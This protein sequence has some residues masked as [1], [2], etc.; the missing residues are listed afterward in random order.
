MEI[1]KIDK[2][3]ITKKT[4]IFFQSQ[5][6]KN[7]LVF[8]VFVTI[9]F[10]FWVMQYF[11]QTMEREIVLSVDY[12]NC[13]KDIVVADSVP[14]ELT[15]KIVD[16][17]TAF[18]KYH[19]SK[20]VLEIDMKD[21]PVDTRN[22][23]TIDR[24]ALNYK[25]IDFLDN[26]SQ[27]TSFKPEVLDVEYATLEKKELPIRINGNLL[28]SPGYIFTD[29]LHIEPSSVWVYG[30]KESI[31]TL[32]YISTVEVNEDNIQKDLDLTIDLE[33]PRNVSL[34]AQKVKVYTGI[35]E[36]T[37]KII[38]LPIVCYNIPENITVRFFPSTA[39]VNCRI[40]LSKYSELNE[41]DLEI[42]INYND[43]KNN[44]R[45]NVPLELV[46]KPEWLISYRIIPGTSEFL[47]EQK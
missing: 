32:L 19:Y 47:F 12:I 31:D 42:G 6:W 41:S 14:R 29:S 34:S 33:T 25:I 22:V 43:I 21:V 16:K 20:P 39:E 30:T 36:Y 7:I 3:K 37:E 2:D 5:T 45:M 8:F 24:N 13:P 44:S 1:K 4:K 15:V 17:G 23:Y 10:C 38:E 11:Q 28:L 9:A 35:E 26:T 27:V 40:A 18:L 46:K